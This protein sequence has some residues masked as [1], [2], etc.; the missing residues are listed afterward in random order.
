MRSS[1][2]GSCCCVS[3][4]SICGSPSENQRLASS[5]SLCY[6][7][8]GK[9][10]AH[11]WGQLISEQLPNGTEYHHNQQQQQNIN[12]SIQYMVIMMT[13]MTM[14]IMMMMTMIIMMAMLI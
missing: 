12:N 10:K 8:S 11:F 2:S 13:M 3:R 7:L 1:G 9:N 5:D 14:I 6:P 4:S